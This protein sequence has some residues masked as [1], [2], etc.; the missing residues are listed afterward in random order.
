M[1]MQQAAILM[2]ANVRMDMHRLIAVNVILASP[3]TAMANVV[4][5]IVVLLEH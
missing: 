4:I 3:R 5:C 2:A 1:E